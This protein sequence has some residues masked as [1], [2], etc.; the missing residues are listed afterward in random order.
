[1]N[2][3]ITVFLVAFFALMNVWHVVETDVNKGSISIILSAAALLLLVFVVPV[4]RVEK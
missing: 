1:M 4:E 3:W 2:R